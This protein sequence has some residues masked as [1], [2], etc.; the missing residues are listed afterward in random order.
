MTDKLR[1]W[2]AYRVSTDRQGA[3][4][5]EIPMQKAQCHDYAQQMGWEITR[6]LTEKLSGYKTAIE[7]RETLKIIKQGAVNGEFD[8]LL[9]YHSDRLG[10]Q[11]EYSLWIASLYELGVQVWSVKEGELKNQEH[12]DALMN[13][14]RYWQSE[15]E[16]KKTSMRIKDAMKQ[17]NE[18]GAYLG[19]T[20]PFG[21]Q[22]EDTGKKRNSKKDK[23]IKKI[24]IN[25]DEAKIVKMMFDWVLERAMGSQLIAQE[26]NSLGLTNR[27]T[28]WRHNQVRRMLRNPVY[29]GYKKY[30]VTKTVGA[31]GNLRKEAKREEWLLQPFNP[32]LVIV[33]EEQ[34]QK[35]Q[36][37]MDKRVKKTGVASESRTPTA[38]NVLLSGLAVCGYCGKKLKADFTNKKNI[39]KDGSVQEY[40]T[41]KYTCH[42]A[43]S[44]PK[45]HNQRQFGA[46][47]IDKQVEEE[48]LDA[49]SSI[50]LDAFN[51]EKDAF[52]FEQ[53]D[54]RKVQL[55]ELEA[56]FEGASKALS[57]VEKLFDDIMSGKS[58]MSLDFVSKKMEE[59]GAKKMELLGKI[60]ALKKEIEEAEVTSSDLDKLKYQLED[61]VDT[62]KNAVSLEQ[63]KAMMAQVLHEV[64]ISKESLTIKFNITIE[65]ALEGSLTADVLGVMDEPTAT[66]TGGPGYTIKC[67]TEG[68]P[69][70]HEPGSLSMAHAGKDTGGSQFFIVHE[71]QPHLNGVHTVF[72]KVTSNLEAAKGMSN[73]D[74]MEKVVVTEE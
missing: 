6:E 21:Y 38:S 11:M 64:V 46:V 1:V 16:S 12:G 65:K 70:K 10:R 36:T 14:I 4:G 2:T 63:K 51:A 43:K 49:I 15:G 3:E 29:M 8:I 35:V 53:L 32:E 58:S 34:F 67:E 9:L 73:G 33:P 18:E 5:D 26:L 40:R 54:A 68:N 47:T 25:P 59:Y 20:I 39:R 19:G 23:T 31:R 69:H 41:Y 48:V 66:G 13:F 30:N 50:Q 72:G 27:G 17:L 42:H 45:G 24:V 56:Q 7:D 28:V 61:W 37:V 44:D 55:K 22:L 60:D 57:N 74:V 71:S 52:D 62:Y